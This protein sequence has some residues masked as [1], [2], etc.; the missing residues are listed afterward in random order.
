M[1]R[2]E[3]RVQKPKG[4]GR[5]QARARTGKGSIK[6]IGVGACLIFLEVKL[7]RVVVFWDS[8]CF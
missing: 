7:G 3:G 5:T 1:I 8:N 2:L 6:D 4:E